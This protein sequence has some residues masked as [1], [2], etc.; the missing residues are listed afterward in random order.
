[1]SNIYKDIF[2]VVRIYYA[3]NDAAM[4]PEINKMSDI[5]FGH[6]VFKNFRGTNIDNATGL[7]LKPLAFNILS[8]TYS[9]NAVDLN[10]YPRLK[11]LTEFD[12]ISTF[13]YY[14]TYQYKQVILFDRHMYITLALCNGSLTNLIQMYS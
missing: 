1:M 14:F 10:E 8:K 2:K 12:R 6:F 13:P 9:H 7:R 5:T 11:D 3:D 4:A